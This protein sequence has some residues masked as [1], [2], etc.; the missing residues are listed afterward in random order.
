GGCYTN[1]E[2]RLV[3]SGVV[4]NLGIQWK[5]YNETRSSLPLEIQMGVSHKLKHAPFRFSLLGQHLQKWDLT[6]N[7][8][9]AKETVDALTGEVIPVNKAGFVEKFARHFVVQT[10]ILFG[11]KLHLRIGFD[12]NRRQE[13][14]LTQRPGIAGFSFGAGMYF[15]RFSIDYGFM[16]YSA[17]GMQ[18]A[19]S[20][21]IPLGGA[22]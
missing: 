20:L 21:S 18:H 16:S 2:K 17:A 11:K 14:K 10:E 8:P 22:K 3:L 6:Y 19:I 12:Y 1:D 4:K 13:L 5:G 9:N 7:D 15:K